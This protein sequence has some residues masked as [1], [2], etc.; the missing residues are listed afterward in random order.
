M[1]E[2]VDRADYAAAL[3]A[4]WRLSFGGDHVAASPVQAAA[5]WSAASSQPGAD[6]AVDWFAATAPK[7]VT[8][9]VLFLLGGPGS[10]KSLIARRAVSGMTLVSAPKP[11]IAE[12]SYRYVAAGAPV[13]LINDATITPDEIPE[14]SPL[15]A[16]LEAAIA[17]GEHVLVNI[18]RG[19]VIEELSKASSRQLATAA[20][21]LLAELGRGM[22]VVADVGATRAVSVRGE[23]P[24][25]GIA[26]SDGARLVVSSLI[27]E[28][29]VCSIFERRVEVNIGAGSVPDLEV[30]KYQI[31]KRSERTS[32]NFHEAPAGDL[33]RK[34]LERLCAVMPTVPSSS[35]DPV[36]SNARSLSSPTVQSALLTTLRSA[37]VVAGRR[38]TFRDVWGILSLLVLGPLPLFGKRLEVEAWLADRQP[39]NHETALVQYGKAKVL[40]GMRFSQSLYCLCEAGDAPQ[41][42]A[43]VGMRMV[44]GIDPV[45]DSES[46]RLWEPNGS[47]WASPVLAAFAGAKLR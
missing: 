47:G 5:F 20:A 45:Q 29:D 15:L 37:E 7:S 28:M 30:G 34:V 17:N 13:L 40:A 1:D 4:L 32:Q 21:N 11:G 19:I 18:N 2:V 12:R 35:L 36:W 6:E 39:Q 14:G 9:L 43:S 44:S 3:D 8:P 46:G 33:V 25:L 41:P 38:F 42:S 16:E 24:V 27:V 26:V 10:G 22:G 23:S 31:W